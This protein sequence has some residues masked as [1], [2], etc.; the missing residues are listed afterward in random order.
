MAVSTLAHGKAFICVSFAT[1]AVR[2]KS[3]PQSIR[4]ESDLSKL[5]AQNTNP[6]LE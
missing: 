3:L 5:M 4:S 6:K 2:A 1:T